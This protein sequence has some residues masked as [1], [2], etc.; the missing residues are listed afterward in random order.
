MKLNHFHSDD[1]QKSIAIVIVVHL[2]VSW[3]GQSA[4]RD[5]FKILAV[6]CC[7]QLCRRQGGRVD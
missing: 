1:T 6:S 2:F 3:W 5:C 4:C 7:D